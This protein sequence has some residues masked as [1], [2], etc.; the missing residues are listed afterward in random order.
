MQVGLGTVEMNLE[1]VRIRVDEIRAQRVDEFRAQRIDE[2]NAIICI[3]I[4]FNLRVMV[5]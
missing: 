4:M 3:V 5:F 1:S 2:K